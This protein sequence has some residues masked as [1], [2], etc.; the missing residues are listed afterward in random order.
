MSNLKNTSLHFKRLLI[1]N[2]AQDPDAARLLEWLLP[3]F[4]GV[5]S[6]DIVYKKYE[7]LSALGRDSDFY[8][9]HTDI[10][11][12]ETKFICA[13]EGWETKDWYKALKEKI[14]E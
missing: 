6:G 5:E 1:D 4:N 11:E 7:F 12:A 10:A 2:S 3:L 9:R 14:K 8:T 13:L